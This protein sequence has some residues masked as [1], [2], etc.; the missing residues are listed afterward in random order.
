MD[1]YLYCNESQINKKYNIMRLIYSKQKLISFFRMVIYDTIY[2][3]NR[4]KFSSET[5]KLLRIPTF[6]KELIRQVRL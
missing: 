4:R 5:N 2:K 1:R 3:S 6:T